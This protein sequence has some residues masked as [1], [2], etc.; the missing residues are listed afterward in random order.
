L[1]IIDPHQHVIPAGTNDQ[2]AP[3]LPSIVPGPTDDM[4]INFAIVDAE[5][6]AT[7]AAVSDMQIVGRPVQDTRSARLIIQS[8]SWILS[9]RL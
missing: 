7:S 2:L 1:Q 6:E 5:Q 8:I 9:R 4:E 3:F